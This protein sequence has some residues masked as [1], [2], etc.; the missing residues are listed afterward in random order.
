MSLLKFEQ[1]IKAVITAVEHEV[2]IL[3]KDAEAIIPF[4]VNTELAI[5]GQDLPKTGNAVE[6]DF[7]TVVKL[8]AQVPALS[9]DAKAIALAAEAVINVAQSIIPK[10]N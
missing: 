10:T 3:V 2:V 4:L 7:L 8:L 9:G 5:K 1:K 6:D